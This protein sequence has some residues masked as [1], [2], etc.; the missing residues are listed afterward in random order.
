MTTKGK[1]WKLSE[2]H[3]DNRRQAPVKHG[4]FSKTMTPE[5][6]ATLAILED[7]LSTRPG[8]VQVQREQ[9]AKAVQ[10]VNAL[11]SY[12]VKK[13]QDGIPLDQIPAINKIP[14]YTNSAVQALKQL[15]DM[16]PDEAQ[17]LDEGAILEHL[18]REDE[19]TG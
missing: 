5:K 2:E 10:I 14:A 18:R 13:Y 4:A 9:T 11:M 15:Y 1:T 7:Q 8:I 12:V 19:E 6:A 17:V 3:T 16:L